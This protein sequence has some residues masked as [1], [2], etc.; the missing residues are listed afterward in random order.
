MGLIPDILK[1]ESSEQNFRI[2]M[3]FCAAGT[4]TGACRLCRTSPCFRVLKMGFSQ[5][6]FE[7]YPFPKLS[8]AQCRISTIFCPIF[9]LNFLSLFGFVLECYYLSWHISLC[10]NMFPCVLVCFGVF[11]SVSECFSVFQCVSMCFRMF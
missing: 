11:Q 6:V 7:L 9:A 1:K 10:F 3:P 2:H 8:I 4:L 5:G